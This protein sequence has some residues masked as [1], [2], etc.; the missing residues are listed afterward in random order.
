VHALIGSNG[1]GKTTILNLISGFYR[2]DGGTIELAGK[3]L[4]TLPAAKVAR[5]GIGRTFQAPK[6]IIRQTLLENIEAAATIANRTSDVASLLR[7]PAGIRARR[8]AR[9][10]AL[11]AIAEVGLSEYADVQVSKLP[12]GLRRLGEVARSL[13]TTPG[14]LLLDEPAAGLT[15]SELELLDQVVRRAAGRGAA[16]LLVEHNVPFVFGLA[17]EVTVLHL[18]QVIARGAPDD[19]RADEAVARAFLGSQVELLDEVV[20]IA[21][22]ETELGP[23]ADQGV[24]SGLEPQHG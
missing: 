10:I 8:Q 6:L 14:V 9:R 24:Q 15:H 17:D 12:H 23:E 11:D 13:A 20:E 7:L 2:V 18:G 21:G 16:V 5:H 1:S 3:R 4:D 22:I 19:I